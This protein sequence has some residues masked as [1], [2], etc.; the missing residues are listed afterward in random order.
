MS[1]NTESG[2]TTIT[3]NSEPVSDDVVCSPHAR[4]LSI[5]A[6]AWALF[7]RPPD[8]DAARVG[9]EQAARF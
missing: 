9:T 4:R 7:A 6:A 5:R 2:P 1:S 8:E 3:N